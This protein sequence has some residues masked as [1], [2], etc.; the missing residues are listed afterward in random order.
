MSK[1]CAHVVSENNGQTL[2]GCAHW[3][4][5]SNS[6]GVVY[7]TCLSWRKYVFWWAV[8]NN[9]CG[10]VKSYPW[11]WYT[12][13]WTVWHAA[14]ACTS[15]HAVQQLYTAVSLWVNLQVQVGRNTTTADIMHVVFFFFFLTCK[16]LGG[17]FNETFPNYTSLSLSLSL[18]SEQQLVRTYFTL[19]ARI[20]PQWLSEPIWL[21]TSIP[22]PVCK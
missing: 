6:H 17:G 12:A 22:W 8:N 20:S 5:S 11:S 7:F 4:V 21:W 13:A 10:V 19:S 2:W 9:P 16:D 18:L 1:A 15:G 3:T 14:Y